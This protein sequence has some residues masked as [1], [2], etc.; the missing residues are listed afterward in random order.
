MLK[1]GFFVKR[2]YRKI[3]TACYAGYLLNILGLLL[4]GVVAGAFLG[5]DAIS[6][7]AVVAPL[8]MLSCFV[9]SLI[10]SGSGT[11]YSREMGKFNKHN[12]D[13]IFSQGLIISLIL[14][15]IT[16]TI[17]SLARPL[18]ISFYDLTGNILIYANDYYS[19]YAFILLVYP[20]YWYLYAMVQN[21]G[22]QKLCAISDTVF[23][24]AHVVGSI[25]GIKLGGIKGLA[26]ATIIA[27]IINA[28]VLALHFFSKKNSLHFIWNFNFGFVKEVVSLG[29]STA[30]T[31]AC[32]SLVDILMNKIIV[33]Y[34]GE[35]YL[36]SYAITN[37]MMSWNDSFSALGESITPFIGVYR[38]ERNSDSVRK[39]AKTALKDAVLIGFLSS[40][41]FVGL[42]K[43]IPYVYS[44]KS[45]ESYIASVHTCLIVGS[46]LISYS[47]GYCLRMYYSIIE[48]PIY[49]I[50][51]GINVSLTFPLLL[52]FILARTVGMDGV[53][54]AIAISS[55][56]ALAL[57]ELVIA[58]K[59]GRSAVPFAIDKTEYKSFSKD[60]ELKSDDAIEEL[61]ASA[62]KELLTYGLEQDVIVRVNNIVKHSLIILKEYNKN[63]TITSECSYM[64][65]D[66]EIKIVIRDDGEIVDLTSLDE[67]GRKIDE[68]SYK[69]LLG[70]DG[71][72]MNLMTT[73][74]NRNSFIIA[75]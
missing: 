15:V 55:V 62:N 69:E 7:V 31:S 49:S 35:T 73:A 18:F 37:L 42:S 28:T 52:G 60:V 45:E 56:L 1:D 22:N 14:S 23:L 38:G 25:V 53:S 71:Q 26:T 30:L 59:E 43:H 68:L 13:T 46:S 12:A 17:V 40:C 20:L 24:I 50:I 67:L 66:Q 29:S 3:L 61:I 75:K 57:T 21:D 16:C 11:V 58:I 47:I 34:V 48:K 10:A 32:D 54:L 39:M 8:Y 72:K 5:E 36:S 19:R 70:S 74:Y 65:S 2:R 4:D 9:G 64:I 27:H 44:I 63:K 33:T 41:L 6:A 51:F